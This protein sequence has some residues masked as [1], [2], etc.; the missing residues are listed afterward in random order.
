MNEVRFL[1]QVKEVKF[2]AWTL[3]P[4]KQC[5]YDGSTERELEP[6]LF[7]LLCY[8]I[9]NNEQIITRQD[10]VDDVWCQKYVDDNAINR[11]M[12]ELRKILKSDLQ[13]GIVVKTHY[14]KGYSFFLEPD[15]IY[16]QELPSEESPTVSAQKPKESNAVP[17]QKAPTMNRTK[18][19]LL[20]L[21][22][23]LFAVGYM[24]TVN[25]QTQD[26]EL[27]IKRK[28]ITEK[29]LSWVP[30][31]YSQLRLSY[32]KKLLAFSFAPQGTKSYS[33]VV[34]EL[35]SGYERRLG[36]EG[37]HYYPL[38]WSTDSSKLYY[39]AKT[40]ETCEVWEINADFSEGNKALFDCNMTGLVTGS[41][42]SKDRI[43]Y[44]KSGYRNRDELAAL[45]SRDLKTGE[46]F[47]ISSPNL[48]SYGDHFLT[49][50]PE[51]EVILFLR[52]QYDTHELYM[53]DLDGGDQVKL[54]E[55]PSRIWSVNY[56]AE[57]D[58]ILWFDN[59]KNIV[60]GYS[61]SQRKLVKKDQLNTSQSYAIF[62]FIDK[63][64][65]LIVSYPFISYIYTLD[66]NNKAVNADI[67]LS[68]GSMGPIKFKQGYLV[69]TD[70]GA[71]KV[72][73][74]VDKNGN[75]EVLAIP[76]G[77]ISNIRYYEQ[78]DLLLVHHRRKIDI[79]QYSDLSLVDSISADGA[80][81]SAEFLSDTE[82]GY[83]VLGEHKVKSSSYKYSLK[84]K[85]NT[86]IPAQNSVWIGRL[87]DETLISLSSN[88]TVVLYDI[89]S[90]TTIQSF[91]L[92]KARYMHSIA[93]GN[94]YIYHS[95]GKRIYRIDRDKENA[96]EEVYEVEASRYVIRSISYS[97]HN[98][99]L[100][101]NII[102]TNENQL[103][104]LK[105]AQ[106]EATY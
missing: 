87:D 94:G 24:F 15:I 1:R 78:K 30:G 54:L 22:L 33:L 69:I 45:T 3:D 76:P 82:V 28:N 8:F 26:D 77:D 50:I 2:G 19:G 65:M 32:D 96:V 42:V 80:I 4:K 68:L 6:L 98:K 17:T 64:E 62:Q 38:G 29:V 43:V 9:I 75:S 35:D 97:P 41:G 70:D 101:M 103:L 5:I 16:H 34:K 85:S 99:A 13:K 55:S 74:Q 71:G 81:I 60:Y 11:A 53:T 56:D 67:Q 25:Y 51:K 63:D 47:Q 58:L 18:L 7:R 31:R 37:V 79:Y 39:R 57:S 84:F 105:I 102:E 106:E 83:V 93:V 52:R 46:E 49:Y 44:S 89:N 21:A 20:L 59:K 73:T 66:F 100:W 88:D 27:Q 12:S 95:D 61:L 90:G 14:R 92:P 72:V 91:D 40:E 23:F 36:D 86:S 48:N 104:E 10:L